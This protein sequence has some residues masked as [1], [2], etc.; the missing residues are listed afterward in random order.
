VNYREVVIILSL[1]SVCLSL[2]LTAVK[3]S[4]KLAI[5]YESTSHTSLFEEFKFTFFF[6]RVDVAGHFASTFLVVL[7]VST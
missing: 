6:P 7:D 2:Y 3:F 5:G 1:R 4:S